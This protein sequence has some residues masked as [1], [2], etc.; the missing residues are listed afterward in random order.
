MDDEA[1][2]SEARFVEYIESLAEVLGYVDRAGPLKDYCT[3]L[4]MPRA[5]E[6]GADRVGGSSVARLGGTSVAAAFRRAVGL[7]GR[8]RVGQG[9]RARRAG[10]GDARPD[11]G[12]DCRRHGLREE[13]RAFGGRGATILR[14]ARQD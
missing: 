10:D 11:R 9:A 14:T 4:L 8:K 6:R 12:L 7:V 13:G 1:R 5:Q 2:A 3:G